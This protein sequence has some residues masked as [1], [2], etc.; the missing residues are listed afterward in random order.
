MNSLKKLKKEFDKKV[1][2]LDE[3]GAVH[4]DFGYKLR[5]KRRFGT[6]IITVS[7]WGNIWQF[8]E[9]AYKE[10]KKEERNRIFGLI[11]LSKETIEKQGTEGGIYSN[12]INDLLDLLK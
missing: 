6:E 10:G 11:K 5:Q 3:I 7:D 9:K 8:I 12:Y 2:G 4:H 1:K